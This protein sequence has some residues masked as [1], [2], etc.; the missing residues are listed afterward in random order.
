MRATPTILAAALALLLPLTACPP[1][2]KPPAKG[3]GK[4]AT[5]SAKASKAN[6]PATPKATPKTAA[7]VKM[8]PPANFDGALEPQPWD[9]VAEVDGAC[10]KH[11]AAAEVLRKQLVAHKGPRDQKTTLEPYNK[12]LIQLDNVLPMA[13]LIAAVHPKKE[14][15]TAAEKCEQKGKK[16]AS[17]LKLDKGLYQALKGVKTDGLDAEAKRFLSHLLRDYRRA[18]VDR[19]D[20]TRKKLT[21]LD[22]K[23]VKLGQTF[24]RNIRED[25]K[26]VLVT[27]AQL[28]GLPKDFIEA[29]KKKAAK[30]KT[31]GGKLTITTDYPSFYPVVSYA[32][33]ENVRKAIYKA[34]LSR[35]APKNDKLLK[36]L[37]SARYTYATTLGYPDWA[38]YNAEDKMVKKK[39]VISDFLAKVVKLARP[40]MLSDLEDVLARKQK[41]YPKT[42]AAGVWDRFYY[43]NKLRAERFGVDPA[44]VR[45]Y[46]DFKNVKKGILELAQ[47]LF[48]LEFKKVDAKAWHASVESYDVYDRGKRIARFYLDLHPRKGKY[49]HAA[50]FSILTGIPGAQLPTASLVTNFPDPSKSSGP[51]LTEHNQVV[52]FFHE[53]G[54]LMHQLLAGRHRWVTLSGITCEWD[55]VEAPSQLLE[56]WAWD[57]KV[58]ARFAK[59]HKTGKPIPAALVA[60]MKKADELGKGMHLMRQMF[61]AYLSFQLHAGDP[62]NI[63][64]MK[65]V[66]TLHKT[67]SPYPYL[68]GTAVQDNFGHINGYSSMY[69]TYMWSLVLAKDLLTRFHKNG[70]LDKATALAYRRD[71]LEPG[72]A[73]DAVDMVK[74]F[75]GRPS[76]F[77]A[78]QKWLQAN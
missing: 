13:E 62:K 33:D 36:E 18:G 26:K 12:L 52:T 14:V 67:V 35:A 11:L 38:E 42:K 10:K 8:P 28:A 9:S 76:T 59:H 2:K 47:E 41:D 32:K 72:G 63:D 4:A 65:V 39:K 58:L 60:K 34:F 75:L 16:L 43:I 66:K 6:K 46:F 23:M 19:D 61:Y 44:E 48:A 57:A 1:A 27:E 29:A 64:L 50:E 17:A 68:E 20:A 53:F 51:A 15:R 3:S 37:L 54:H 71:I 40:R 73:I 69:Y 21:A 30:D 7:K 70:L 25:R 74:A 45:A 22:A 55:F 49:G 56:D 77:D 24:A 31:P 78:Y 5:G